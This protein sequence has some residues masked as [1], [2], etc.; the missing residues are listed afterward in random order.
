MANEIQPASAGTGGF[1][2][3]VDL[4][5]RLRKPNLTGSELSEYLSLKF[6]WKVAPA[7][8]AKW[9]S[10]GGGP[11]FYKPSCTPLYPTQTADEWALARLGKLKSSTSDTEGAAQ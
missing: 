1:C 2:L 8:L 5:V 7:T 9:R 4:P 6:G 11:P 10:V 3:P